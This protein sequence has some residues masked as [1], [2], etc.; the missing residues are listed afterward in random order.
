MKLLPRLRYILEVMRPSPQ[1][2]QDVLQILTRVARHS[3]SSATEV[4]RVKGA[5]HKLTGSLQ[6]FISSSG[7]EL[8]SSDGDGNVRVSPHFLVGIFLTQP[9]VH[10]WSSCAQRHEALEGLGYIWQT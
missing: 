6:P 4:R 10:I 9:S 3:L 5:A 7:V 1:V 8:S 2:A